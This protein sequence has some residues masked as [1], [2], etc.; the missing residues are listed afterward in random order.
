MRFRL[1]VFLDYVERINM[2]ALPTPKLIRASG[3]RS[4]ALGCLGRAV[5]MLPTVG[6]PPRGRLC[7]QVAAEVDLHVLSHAAWRFSRYPTAALRDV[8]G[9][10]HLMSRISNACER[11]WVPRPTFLRVRSVRRIFVIAM[12]RVHSQYA[13]GPVVQHS[14]SVPENASSREFGRNKACS[15]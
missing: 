15:T 1:M 7:R 9:L 2:F 3:A 13:E 8:I 4:T 5:P 12:L 11:C 14:L 6:A 10:S